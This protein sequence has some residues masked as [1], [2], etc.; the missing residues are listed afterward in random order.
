MAAKKTSNG[1]TTSAPVRGAE[2]MAQAIERARGGA[3]P[4]PEPVPAD[5]LDR[6]TLPNEEPLTPAL[7][8][9]LAFDASW[10]GVQ[11]D[12]EDA[13]FESLDL[14]E[15]VENELGEDAV[16]LFEEA[17]ELLGDDCIPLHGRT[18][19]NVHPFLYVGNPDEAAGEFPVITISLSGETPAVSGFVPFDVWAA[20]ELGA[21]PAGEKGELPEGY[22]DLAKEL[23]KKNADG[24]V[25]FEPTPLDD[26]D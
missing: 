12:D 6:L 3:I 14:E 18:S 23:A 16:P 2:L 22:R 13:I 1:S 15:V 20:I 26:E 10:L 4:K 7:R 19:R 8:A 25:A 9:L 11:I 24:R 21:L 17:Y 5:L